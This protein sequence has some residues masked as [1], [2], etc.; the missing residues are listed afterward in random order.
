MPI[1]LT[2]DE[3]EIEVM[4]EELAQQWRRG[5]GIEPFLRGLEPEL[6]RRVREQ[7]WSWESMA[8][9][10]NRAGITYQSGRLWTGQTL[11]NKVRDI[12]F[13]MRVRA[14][15]AMSNVRPNLPGAMSPAIVGPPVT[16]EIR[17][18]PADETPEEPEFKPAYLI[19]GWKPKPIAE[20]LAPVARNPDTKPAATVDVDAVIARLLGKT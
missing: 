9:A 4:A 2:R 5:D 14:N 19:G 7:H 6:S 16:Q 1:K 11:G 20:S 13:K 18:I 17:E 15:K 12:R 10:F 3:D 8:L